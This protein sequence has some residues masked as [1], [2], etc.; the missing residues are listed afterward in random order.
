[1]L[2]LWSRGIAIRAKICVKCGVEQA[3]LVEEVSDAWHLLPF[4]FSIIGGLIAWVANKDRN[5]KKARNFLIFGFIW[6]IAG[7]IIYFL[8]IAA[9][10][11]AIFSSFPW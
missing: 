3:P 7:S 2:E 1:M 8:F 11:A 4:F 10:F 5:P 9:F 6:A